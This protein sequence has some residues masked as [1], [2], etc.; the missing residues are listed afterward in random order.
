MVEQ[1]EKT[2][3]YNVPVDVPKN[4]IYLEIIGFWPDTEAV[5]DYINR[6]KEAVSMVKRNFTMVVDARKMIVG[7]PEVK[8]IH[9]TVQKLV[10][11]AGLFQAAEI[12]PE[13]VIAKMQTDSLAKKTQIKKG[14]FRSVKDGERWLEKELK[15]EQKGAGVTEP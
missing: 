6:V 9:E 12:V 8:K 14:M 11:E 4:R 10:T 5:P 2:K 1:I 15:N 7:P 13:N 3:Y